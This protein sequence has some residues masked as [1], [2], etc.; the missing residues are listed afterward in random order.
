MRPKPVII[1][2]MDSERRDLRLFFRLNVFY[3]LL[4][5]VGWIGTTLMPDISSYLPIGNIERLLNYGGS[6]SFN[7]VEIHASQV[8]TEFDSLIWLLTAIIG[9]VILMLPVSWIYISIREL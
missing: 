1:L 7:N 5:L 8:V 3:S 4:L 6:E 2:H 9:S